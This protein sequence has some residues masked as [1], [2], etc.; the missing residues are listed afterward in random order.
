[1]FMR[2]MMTKKWEQKLNSMILS[3]GHQNLP[4]LGPISFNISLETG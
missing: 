1:M 3:F 4:S 2:N